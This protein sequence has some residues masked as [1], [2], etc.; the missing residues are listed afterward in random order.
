MANEK[1]QDLFESYKT[2]AEERRRLNEMD[3][4]EEEARYKGFIVSG[5]KS[6]LPQEPDNT[7]IAFSLDAET[8]EMQEK[9]RL[10]Y[11]AAR[12]SIKNLMLLQPDNVT[13]GQF[14][15]TER[16]ENILTLITDQLQRFMTRGDD[17]PIDLF[18][19]PYVVIKCDEA[20]GRNN[21]RAVIKE[22]LDLA[23]KTFA[24]RWRPAGSARGVKT[25]GTIITTVHDHIGSNFITLNFNKWAIPFL[26]YFGKGVGG[27]IFNKSIALSLRGDRTK[28]IYKFLCSQR[29]ETTFYYPI[30]QF[31]KDFELGSDKEYTNYQISHDILDKAKK[32]IFE[33]ESD[34]WFDYEMITRFPKNDG[35]KPK[36]D[37]ILFLIKTQETAAVGSPQRARQ[38]L[39]N[40]WTKRAMNYPVDSTADDAVKTIL[41][42]PRCEDYYNRLCYWREAIKNK[43]MSPAHV[44][45]SWA[46][47][48]R[49]DFNIEIVKPKKNRK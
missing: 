29:D 22:A 16:Q 31:R 12:K 44:Q 24:F 13:F 28:R 34:V 9:A 32:R 6:D 47:V 26:L 5:K 19:E 7:I 21:K 18:G 49:E 11:E 39:I 4:A 23:K 41:N 35:R 45:N 3:A 20:A 30:K 43:E 14:S 48:L 27:T 38:E 2:E 40:Y 1:Q 46:K 37:T 36:A 17:I 42:S 8:G 33:S 10:R 15:V 25:Y